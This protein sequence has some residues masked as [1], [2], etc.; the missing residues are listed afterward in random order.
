MICARRA[1]PQAAKHNMDFDSLISWGKAFYILTPIPASDVYAER[2]MQAMLNGGAKINWDNF[3][4]I[5]IVK[6]SCGTYA[7]YCNCSHACAWL[8]LKGIFEDYP[9]TMHPARVGGGDGDDGA[10]VADL[11]PHRIAASVRGGAL[12]KR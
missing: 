7:H 3:V 8:V 2:I 5:G 6:C 4:K 11:R 10:N 1:P 9:L 12:G